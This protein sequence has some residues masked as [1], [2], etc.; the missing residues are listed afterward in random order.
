MQGF[1]SGMTQLKN[2]T[3]ETNRELTIYLALGRRIGDEKITRLIRL[4]QEGRITAEM[5][6]RALV[7]LTAASG[8]WGWLLGLGQAA[9]GSLMLADIVTRDEVGSEGPQ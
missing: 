4:F 9:L 3:R 8:P 7:T 2:A 6:T 1:F 5:L